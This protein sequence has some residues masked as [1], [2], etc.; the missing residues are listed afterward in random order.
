[1]L[2][3]ASGSLR[4]TAGCPCHPRVLKRPGQGWIPGTWLSGWRCSLPSS[5]G[6]G[7]ATEQCQKLLKFTGTPNTTKRHQKKSLMTWCSAF[8]LLSIWR[9][10]TLSQ[11]S[12]APLQEMRAGSGAGVV[13]VAESMTWGVHNSCLTPDRGLWKGVLFCFQVNFSLLTISMFLEVL[14]GMFFLS[15]FAKDS[16]G[17]FSSTVSTIL[18]QPEVCS[19]ISWGCFEC[20]NAV[21]C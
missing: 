19:E 13:L 4:P 7:R 18:I 14:L 2:G 6:T 11:W 12:Q 16:W 3:R 8:C 21:S 20:R 15:Y 10:L 9:F 17:V 1:M 5:G